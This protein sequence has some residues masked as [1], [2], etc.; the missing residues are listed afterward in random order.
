MRWSL[1][2]QLI[3]QQIISGLAIGMTYALIAIGYTMVYG[4]LKFI[5][6]GHGAVYMVGTYIAFFSWMYLI[7][8]IPIWPSFI[9]ALLI[10]MILAA[11]FGI[12]MEKVAYKPIRGKSRLTT[13]M[14]SLGVS[15]FVTYGMEY[16]VGSSPR[17]TPS[18]FVGIRFNLFGATITGMQIFMLIIAVLLVLGL[19][20]FVKNTR[21]GKA[22][23]ACSEDPGAAY[24]MGI[25]LDTAISATFA[26]G[27]ALGAVSGILIGIYYS[28]VYP[29]MG[30][31]AGL[32]GFIAA[33]VG[34]IGSIP[35][36]MVGGLILGLAE[37][38][39]AGFLT[40]GYRDA[41]AFTVLV[42][43]MLFRPM[44][45]FRKEQRSSL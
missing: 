5:N 21:L 40:S 31:T 35:G 18:L 13:F 8:I 44:G 27:S 2:Y 28:S 19:Q 15:L 42:V 25:N 37:N 9:L 22:I 41:I 1:P 7:K 4:I 34:G 11:A 30:W 36:A 10:A 20:W 16:L 38:L 33:V 12:L 43:V 14:S 26:I 32:K 45:I 39:G 17:P 6:F 23:R 24:L 3:L 29:T